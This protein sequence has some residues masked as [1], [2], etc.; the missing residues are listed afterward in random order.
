MR[1]VLSFNT[2]R[3]TTV[4]VEPL[5]LA[6]TQACQPASEGHAYAALNSYQLPWMLGVGESGPE[7]RLRSGAHRLP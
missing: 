7:S 3:A 4:V 5:Q 6:W 1:G 2:L